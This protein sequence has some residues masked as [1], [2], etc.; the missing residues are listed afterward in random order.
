MAKVKAKAKEKSFVYWNPECPSPPFP[1]TN[2]KGLG[3]WHG[4]DQP[5]SNPGSLLLSVSLWASLS[6]PRFLHAEEEACS[7]PVCGMKGADACRAHGFSE[8]TPSYRAVLLAPD[9]PRGGMS[10]GQ[11]FPTIPLGSTES[12]GP[13]TFR[14]RTGEVTASQGKFIA[15]P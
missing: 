5:G 15:F 3:E 7:P 11:T 12:L 2:G 4:Q 6:G 13:W 14:A 9:G 10:N 1:G 8:R